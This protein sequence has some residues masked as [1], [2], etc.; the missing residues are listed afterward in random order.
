MMAAMGGIGYHWRA[1]RYRNDLWGE[2][3]VQIAQWL[4]Q[5]KQIHRD[6]LL[7]GPSAGYSLP[8]EFLS[9]YEK[10]WV[11]EVD[12]FARI[13]FRQRFSVINRPVE[14]VKDLP[15]FFKIPRPVDVLF[16][17]I[18]GQLAV[19]AKSARHLL[20]Q[21]P[22]NSHFASYHDLFSFH[23]KYQ[24]R[25]H[26]LHVE[27]EV[28]EQEL[29]HRFLQFHKEDGKE[30]ND[31][32]VLEDHGLLNFFPPSKRRILHWE[33]VPNRHHLIECVSSNTF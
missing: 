7:I 22:A 21:L 8:K 23:G 15:S 10:I 16:C 14:F 30:K 24:W 13:L 17:N 29:L 18:L 20:N 12:V 5:W 1:A 3:R 2:Y 19:T 27:G 28:S 11:C 25:S 9:R 6:I 32:I 33:I 31:E 4:A 26:G